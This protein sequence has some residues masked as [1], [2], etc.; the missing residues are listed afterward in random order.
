MS[1]SVAKNLTT[2]QLLK[3]P[4]AQLAELYNRGKISDQQMKSF[5]PHIL[6]AF[7]T[8]A[9]LHRDAQEAA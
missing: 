1:K 8:L 4:A 7:V 6:G 5:E 9:K 3:L 2:A